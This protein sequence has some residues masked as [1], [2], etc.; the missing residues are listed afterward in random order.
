M[1]TCQGGWAVVTE[2]RGGQGREK[3]MALVWNGGEIWGER[4]KPFI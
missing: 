2:W 3:K 1:G 4:V